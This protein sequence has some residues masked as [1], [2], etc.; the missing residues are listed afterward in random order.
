LLSILWSILKREFQIIIQGEKMFD[1][2]RDTLDFD[3]LLFETRNRDYGAYQLRKRYN[4]V[5]VAGI[6]LGSLMVAAAVILPFVISPHS[7]KVLTGGIS[8]VQVQMENLDPPVDEI[9]VPPPPPP[10]EAARMQEI[11]K[12]VPPVVVDSVLP[13][14]ESQTTTDDILAQP[15]T[16]NIE[17]GGSGTGN[18]LLSGQEGI[19]TNEAFFIVEVMP[20]FKGGDINKFREWVMRRTNYPQAAVDNRIQGKVYL[21]FIVETDGTVS[22][23]TIVKGVDPLIDVEAVRTIQSSPKW[24]PGLQRGQP[25]RVRYS[26]SLSFSL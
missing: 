8:Y 15:T 18:D 23:V 16:E 2:L 25:V 19:E 26:M 9:V 12:Y 1:N 21:T 20:S 24:S 13:L 6:I 14:E 17:A 7:D 22:N 3:D 4:S 10:S 5:M 11:V